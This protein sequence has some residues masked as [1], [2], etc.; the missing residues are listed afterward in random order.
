M[1]IIVIHQN[2]PGQFTQAW[3]QVL[4]S[5]ILSSALFTALLTV[6]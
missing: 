3:G 4:Q 6:A 2:F 5:C 1:N